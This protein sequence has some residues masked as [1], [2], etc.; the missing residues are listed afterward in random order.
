MAEVHLG[1]FCVCRRKYGVLVEQEIS[2]GSTLNNG[3]RI[4]GNGICVMRD[5]L[6]TYS[7]GITSSVLAYFF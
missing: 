3:D 7:C 5:V 1:I 2:C 4:S 6:A